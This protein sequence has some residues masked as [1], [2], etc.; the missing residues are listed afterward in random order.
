MSIKAR[1]LSALRW[2]LA[3]KAA[4][5]A[6][7]WAITLYVIRVLDPEVFGLMALAAV[8]IEAASLVSSAGLD[9][10]LIQKHTL[11]EADI[12]RFFGGVLLS[13]STVFLLVY[14][15]AETV[16]SI[17]GEE[18]LALIIHVLA[19]KILIDA[20]VVVPTALLRRQMEFRALSLID[21]L[22]TMMSALAVLGLVLLGFGIWSLVVGRLVNVG[23]KALGILTV[24]R[25]HHVPEFRL[26]KL[27]PEFRFGVRI[28]AQSLV[29]F[30]GRRS[31]TIL[32]GRLLGTELLGLFTIGRNVAKVPSGLIM[33]SVRQIGFPAYSRLQDD[34]ETARHY[35]LRSVETVGFVFVPLMW[36]LA[37]VAEEVVLFFL[38]SNWASAIPVVQLLSW[39]MPVAIIMRLFRPILNAIGRPDVEFRNLL[40]TA[41][42]LP[43]AVAAGSLWGLL[44]ATGGWIAAH[45]LASTINLRRTMP[46]L[47]ASTA[48]MLST[49]LP[50]V[51]TSLAMCAVVLATKFYLLD[52]IAVAA[53]LAILLPLGILVYCGLAFA[54]SR[55]TFLRTASLLRS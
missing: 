39:G 8:T 54:V 19:L 17:F 55:D 36:G 45:V 4:A 18:S 33:Q 26:V 31:D 27:A 44:G 14:L 22:A 25:F 41:V 5:K 7:T 32:I 30:L 3:G 15:G 6:A 37:C 21:I 2:N 46:V 34:K 50:A 52:G 16:A 13:G 12:R 42:C 51:I 20:M 49:I 35:F 43:T 47:E 1:A 23:V 24:T 29:S 28:M 11:D 9:S 10:A 53:R 40:T 48:R 38:G